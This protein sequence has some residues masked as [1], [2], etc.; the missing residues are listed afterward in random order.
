MKDKPD[1]VIVWGVGKG[2]WKLHNFLKFHESIGDIKIVAYVSKYKE[3]RYIN[4]FEVIEPWE[5]PKHNLTYQYILVTTDNFYKEIIKEYS[6]KLHIDRKRF[7]KGSVIQLPF[8]DWKKYIKI[9]NSNL[10]IISEVCFGGILSKRLGFALNSPFVNVRIGT[11]K[12]DFFEF[13]E[14]INKYMLE[15]PSLECN[16]YIETNSWCGEEFGRVKYPLLRYDN[17]ILHGFHYKTQ[18]D[19]LEDW[20]KRRKRYNFQNNI[21]FKILYD[22][23]DIEK[24]EN[25]PFTYKLGFY[26]KETR[27][28]NIITIPFNEIYWAYSWMTYINQITISGELFNYVDFFE[29]LSRPLCVHK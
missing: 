12:N 27:C 21:V 23:K 16:K 8:F 4:G 19:F 15:S 2:Y 25:I 28:E 7:L 26:Y 14:N 17:I 9:Y 20:E 24:F 22:E 5:I 13:L 6:E 29:L 3:T 10:S 18:K 1:N 11:K